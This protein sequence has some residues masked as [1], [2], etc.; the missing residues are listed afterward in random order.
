MAHKLF[1][2][3]SCQSQA[4]VTGWFTGAAVRKCL[5]GIEKQDSHSV[6]LSKQLRQGVDRYWFRIYAVPGCSNNF[7]MKTLTGSA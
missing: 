7:K 5:Y 6:A 2:V 4:S 3:H 1:A